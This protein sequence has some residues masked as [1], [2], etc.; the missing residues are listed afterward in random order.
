M[1]N[2][3]NYLNRHLRWQDIS[4]TQLSTVNNFLLATSTAFIGFVFKEN[5]L[6]QT[7]FS[8]CNADKLHTFYAF[9]ILL[10]A[11]SVLSGVI[12][13]MARLKDF[14]I[15]RHVTLI[16]KNFFKYNDK[17]NIDENLKKLCKSDF[18]EPKIFK[19]L[20]SLFSKPSFITKNEIEV[21]KSNFD[22]CK[23]NALREA[24]SNLGYLTWLSTKFQ[25]VTFFISIAFYIS[26][27]FA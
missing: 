12:V 5:I 14:R 17:S 13:L 7:S 4:I 20:D 9:S 22:I 1:T 26:Y 21:S 16:R 24:C 23:F 10:M 3:E 19:M 2:Y 25:V 11:F 6:N 27:L 18:P 15:T 8:L